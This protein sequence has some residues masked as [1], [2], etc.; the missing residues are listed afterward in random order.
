M[1]L[2]Y[3]SARG[4][5]ALI[6]S[7]LGSGM[8]FVDATAVNVA[9]PAIEAD[10]HTG[11]AGL[12]WILNGYLLALAS[13]VLPG[14]SLGDTYGRRRVFLI[15]VSGFAAA[16]VLC[17]LAPTAGVLIGARVLQGIAAAL[18]VPVTWIVRVC[19]TGV[20]LVAAKSWAWISEGK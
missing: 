19:W 12:Q 18:L 8:A 11:F 6:A 17:G 3:R 7:I 4:R 16:S 9:L 2:R 13:L 5:F 20:R 1:R 10:L 14:G 15:G